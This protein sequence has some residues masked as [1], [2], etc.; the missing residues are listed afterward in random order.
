MNAQETSQ[1]RRR[2]TSRRIPLKFPLWFRHPASP[3]APREG[4]THDVSVSGLNFATEECLD[5]STPLKLSFDNMPGDRHARQI[6]A[7]VVRAELEE[8]TGKYLIGVKFTNLDEESRAAITAA[9]QKT[10]IMGLLRLADKA[11][12][13]DLHLCAH[14]PPFIR[15]AGQLR[16][17]RKQTLN[18]PDLADMLHSLLTEQQQQLFEQQHELNF[19]LSVTPTLRFRVNLHRQRGHVEATCRRIEPVTRTFSELNLPDVMQHFADFRD[20]L[21]L[22]TGPTG[23]GKTTTLAAMV[24]HINATRT[25]VI[26]T[27][28][29]PIEYVYAY[30][31][32]MI[33]QRE[34]GIDTLSYPAALKEAMR[35][36]PDVIVIGEIRDEETMQVTLDAAETGHLV[37]AT[38]PATNCMQAILRTYR[39]FP[40]ERHAE[41]QMQLASCLRGIISLN[42]HPRVDQPGVV[43]VTEVLTR[44]EAV[45]KIIRTGA[46]E[47][48]P[49]A[50]QTGYK[51]GMHSR[52]HSLERL[53]DAG[54]LRPKHVAKKT[55]AG[56]QEGKVTSTTR[57]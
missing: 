14:H 26:I 51:Y 36:D 16:P 35:Q 42:L 30:K 55:P 32:S 54:Y 22:V 46:L 25:A 56:R 2:R 6:S 48:I 43:P 40:Q 17:L 29:Q 12:A 24:E 10:D 34:I 13:S 19:S 5:I 52:E 20:G 23:A 8:I 7:I 57:A 21:V 53:Q 49:S 33:K 31:N 38:L 27:L 28:E 18:S 41:I 47:Q 11:D 50:I 9:L 3:D 15:V 39:F 44:T 45:A 37:L 4:S 1:G